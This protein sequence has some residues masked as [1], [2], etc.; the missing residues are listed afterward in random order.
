M[1][2][3]CLSGCKPVR[4]CKVMDGLDRIETTT[5]YLEWAHSQSEDAAS[6]MTIRMSSSAEVDRSY[7]SGD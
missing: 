4:Q 5:A 2:A 6:V 1:C 3:L 7:E